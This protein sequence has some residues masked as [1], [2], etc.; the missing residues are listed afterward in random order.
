[1]SGCRLGRGT[2]RGTRAPLSRRLEVNLGLT[3]GL[4]A[5][6]T[7]LLRAHLRGVSQEGGAYDIAAA[8]RG[9]SGRARLGSPTAVGNTPTSG[10]EIA[11]ENVWG[12]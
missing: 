11:N 2:R 12:N 4:R 7:H 5:K 6:R 3:T 10:S 9:V 8:R 1:M